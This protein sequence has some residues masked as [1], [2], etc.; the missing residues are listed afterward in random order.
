MPQNLRD[1]LEEIRAMAVEQK[2]RTVVVVAVAAMEEV[3]V[4]K[5]DEEVVVA[6]VAMVLE[7]TLAVQTEIIII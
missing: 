3:A 1:L 7:T 4:M 6:L 2:A 5:A